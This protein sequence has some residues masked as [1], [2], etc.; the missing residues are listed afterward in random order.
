METQWTQFLEQLMRMI[1]DLTAV[2]FLVPLIVLVVSLLKR[3]PALSSVPANALHLVIQVITWA[4]YAVA[5][6]YG[7]GG[8]FESWIT[9]L[10]PLLQLVVSYLGGAWLY[11]Q[12]KQANMPLWG[13]QRPYKFMD[14]LS[15][16]G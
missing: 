9:A 16:R 11:N 15:G 14:D 1:I 10:I 13:Y 7:K 4:L 2:P 8:E 6:H 12:A 5:Q 3:A